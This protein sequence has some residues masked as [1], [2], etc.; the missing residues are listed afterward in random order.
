[1]SIYAQALAVSFLLFIAATGA[2]HLLLHL[3]AFRPLR[4]RITLRSLLDQPAAYQGYEPPLS[5]I[6]P[7]FDEE[8]NIVDTVQTLLAL[9]YPEFEV[10]VVNDGSADGT[11]V[12]LERAFELEPFPEVYWRR[13]ATKPIRAIFRSRLQPRLRVVDKESGG[14]SDALNAGINASRYPLFCALD[15][16]SLLHRDSLRRAAEPFLDDPNTVASGAAVRLANGCAI[17]DNRVTAIE[18]PRT[19]VGMLQVSEYLRSY[20]FA[21][22]GW[23]QLKGALLMSGAM[24]V[25]R[26]DA[27][28]EAGGFRSETLGA[29]TEL[30]MRLHRLLRGRGEDYSVHFVPDAVSW[31][32]A[33]E[34]LAALKRQ[35]IRR[36]WGLAE[37]LHANSALL[38]SSGGA[39]ATFAYLFLL[40]FECFGPPIEIAAYA[41][42]AAMFAL[43]QLPAAFVAA[44]AAAVFALGFLV[45]VSALLLEEYSFRLYP[46]ADQLARLALTAAIENLGYRQ[47]VAFWRTV[48]LVQWARSRIAAGTP[49]R[50]ELPG[51]GRPWL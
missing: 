26:K 24:A 35:H 38:G 36:Q 37:S 7:A 14:R 4:R 2:G 10:V 33:P 49:E 32:L 40:V 50:H 27:V 23:A 43:G 28:V 13:L 8:A 46:R 9:D 39:G 12:A 47:L 41:Y 51:R 16:H 19:T 18:L 34:E 3:L 31:S 15:A 44:F 48:G 25:F 6:V 11:L 30:T 20:P 42:V 29:A 5:L 17:A 45:S 1:V 22:L 21:R